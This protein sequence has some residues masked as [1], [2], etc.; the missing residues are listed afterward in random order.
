MAPP[1]AQSSPLGQSLPPEKEEKG[2]ERVR[3]RRERKRKGGDEPET[4]S[5]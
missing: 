4:L 2:G 1:F 3:E 5:G